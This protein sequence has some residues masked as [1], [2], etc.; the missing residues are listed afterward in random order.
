[1]LAL[2]LSSFSAW[3]AIDSVRLIGKGFPGFFL[4]DNGSLVSFHRPTWTGSEADL[5]L[6]GGRVTAFE[7]EAFRGGE[8]VL[9]AAA[10]VPFGT[11]LRYT[12]VNRGES[13]DVVVPTMRLSRSDWL[14]TFGNYLLNAIFCFAIAVVALALRPEI[15]ASRALAAVLILLGLVLVLSIDLFASY[16]MVPAYFLAQALTP[17]AIMALLLVFPVPRFSE[18]T[19]NRLIVL[20]FIVGVGIGAANFALL[21]PQ[22]EVARALTLAVLTGIGIAGVATVANLG[23]ATLRA[24]AVQARMQAAIVFSGALVSFLLPSI[25]MGAF[26]ILGWSFS[27]TWVTGFI[28][29]FPVSVLYAIVRHE[30][31]DAERFVRTTLGYAVATSALVIGYA[32]LITTAELLAAPDSLARPAASF[33]VL[34]LLAITFDPVRQAVQRQIDRVF[35]RSVSDAGQVLEAS[36][37][38][39]VDLREE[40]P[41]RD[42]VERR[43]CDALALRWAGAGEEA[44]PSEG[45]SVSVPIVFRGDFLGYLTAGPK[46]SGAPFSH[47]DHELIGGLATQV[48]LAVHNARA[49][50][51]LKEAQEALLRSERLAV[52]GEFAGAVAHG[53]RNPLSGIR[54]SAQIAQAQTSE[55]ETADALKGVLSEADR[56]DQR[57]RSLLEL[58]RPFEPSIRSVRVS[59]VLDAV[60]STMIRRAERQGTTIEVTTPEDLHLFA[61][62]DYL[63]EALLE[64]T[65]NALRALSQQTGSIQFLAEV[66]REGV[67]IRVIDSGPGVTESVHERIF[68]LFF[69]TR[70]EGNG[71]GLAAV[72]RIIERLGGEVRLEASEPGRTCFEI[73]LPQAPPDTSAP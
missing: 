43:L 47:A 19:R 61:D 41:I 55:P 35:F 9:L 13:R 5:P 33:L 29:F 72:R 58:S 65:G 50:S 62:P 54:A 1:M 39:L 52:L 36:G 32:S 49:I 73:T 21:K 24:A 27:F 23:R 18:H 26:A 64:L 46:L 14:F 12:I 59:E 17:P 11:P 34:V 4:W 63:E 60:R 44:E 28:F 10:R 37:A 20:G 42:E 3:V 30:L 67:V 15:S 2:I 51:A 31:F 66:R 45:A 70:A 40:G 71:V 68:D 22:P 57:I 7:G 69:T 53:I 16:R 25:L 48:A 8:S 56:L 6:N 38:A